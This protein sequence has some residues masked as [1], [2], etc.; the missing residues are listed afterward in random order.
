MSESADVVVV[1]AG[2]FGTSIAFQLVNRGAGSVVLVDRAG[3]AAGISGRTFG[4]VRRHYSNELTIRLANR[5]FE[6]LG[7]WTDEVGIGD[8]GYVA[9]G[10]VLMVPEE[11]VAACRE[12]VEL[13]RRLG[14][15]TR[16]VSPAEIADIE[17]LVSLDGVAGG[18]YE[19]DGGFV[20]VTKMI[21][22]WFAAGAARGLGSAFGEAVT[23]VQAEGGRVTGVRTERGVIQSPV[24]VNAAGAWGRDL[25]A[26]LGVELPITFTRVQ[27]AV[28][29]QP[30]HRPMIRTAVTDSAAGLVMR[31]DRGPLALAVVYEKELVLEERAE[32]DLGVDAGYEARVRATLA[33]RVPEYA[34]ATWAGGA[35][36]VYDVTPDWHP[37]LG[38]A[39]G[40]EGLYLALGWSGHGLK[41]APAIGEVVADEVLGRAPKIDVSALRFERFAEGRPMR[42]AYGPGARA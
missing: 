25:V 24:I 29:R 2:I 23:G 22:S 6:V 11:Q 36:G 10:Y 5:G 20:D 30:A 13:G 40:V 1:G 21:L 27:M 18:A 42:L 41:L 19:P 4:Q 15:D 32:P 14:V 17:P 3:P 37:I 33:D 16:F 12:N 31:P 38:W 28:L 26:P 8:P 39:P 9:T 7:A 35:S 34:D